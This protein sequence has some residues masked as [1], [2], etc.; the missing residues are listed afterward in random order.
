MPKVSII[1]PCLNSQKYIRETMDSVVRQTLR[2][3]EIL[4]VDAGSTDGTLEILLEY[5]ENDTRVRLLRSD[6]KSMGYQYNMGIDASKGDY[7]GFVETDDFIELT[8]YEELYAIIEANNVDY[9]K[10]D[11]DMFADFPGERLFVRYRLLTPEYRRLYGKTINAIDYPELVLRDINIW[12]GLYSKEFINS[13]KIRF[14]ETPGA[15]F[16]DMGFALQ[17]LIFADRAMYVEYS[18]YRY[19]RDNLDSSVFNKNT[20]AYVI[21]EFEYTLQCLPYASSAIHRLCEPLINTRFF[22]SFSNTLRSASLQNETLNDEIFDRALSF[23]KIFQAAYENADAAARSWI[24]PEQSK[25]MLS[26][27]SDYKQ[28]CTRS[29]QMA[30]LNKKLLWDWVKFLK[31][32][33]EVVLFGA[34]EIGGSVY[35]YLKRNGV[36]IIGFCDNNANRWGTRYMSRNVYSPPEIASKYPDA[37]Y[38][39]SVGDDYTLGIKSQLI[40]SGID[41]GKI[42]RYVNL[43]AP[44]TAFEYAI[45]P[46]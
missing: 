20:C 15:A 17:V 31:M 45:L 24:S 36:D 14:N 23:R 26:F 16:Q 41:P 43:L 1:I 11:F 10:S 2:D 38:V 12:N 46:D 30:E 28:F 18:H 35:C 19:R 3:I 6:K 37:A 13:K 4:V 8:M 29:K 32:Q 22:E 7:I 34:G 9:V 40:K 44:H 25:E 21:W 33:P 27:I 5:A 42:C 39:I